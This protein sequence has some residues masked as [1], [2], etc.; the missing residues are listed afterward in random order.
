MRKILVRRGLR[1]TEN[2]FTIKSQLLGEFI[3]NFKHSYS[4][5]IRPSVRV[6][7]RHTIQQNWGTL[8]APPPNPGLRAMTGHRVRSYTL[9]N[10]S[11]MIKVDQRHGGHLI[12]CPHPSKM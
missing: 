7:S 3:A 9:Q 12:L 11:F 4:Q 6:A 5:D 8:C 1:T 2:I 10:M